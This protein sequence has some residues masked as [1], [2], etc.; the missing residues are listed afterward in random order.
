MSSMRGLRCVMVACLACSLSLTAVPTALAGES[1]VPKWVRP[2][3]RYLAREGLLEKKKFHAN[4]PMTRKAFRALM[5]RAF[6]AG[7]YKAKRGR[8][9]A[10]EVSLALVKALHRRSL[11][12][13]LRKATSPGGWRP[14]THRWFGSEIV[15]REL[16]L[17]R[18]RP[19]NEDVFEASPRELMRQADIAW[20]VWKAK[21]APE[22]YAAD[23]L[24]D[25]KLSKYD[26]KRRKVVQFA[27]SLVGAP[28]VWAGEWPVETPNAY[29]YGAQVHGGFD[30]SGF[31]WYVLRAKARHWHPID[32]PYK[33]WKLEERSSSGMAAGAKKKLKYKKLRPTDIL[34]FAPGG[35]KAKARSIYHAGLYLGR[36]WMIHSSGSRA[37]ISLADVSPGA[38]WHD[39]FAWGRR[40]VKP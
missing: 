36:G 20:A 13:R 12:R 30:C 8:V 9:T 16:G 15:A 37:G 29:P 7:F 28:Y 33:G 34:F 27:T 31:V 21:T 38:W 23:A 6:G 4:R 3:A 40:V 24:G 1:S 2:A 39:Q 22:F 26:K 11:A 17:R 5:R 35:R 10:R 18:D 25:F 14:R 32:R 19:T